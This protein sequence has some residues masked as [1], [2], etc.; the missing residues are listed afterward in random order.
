MALHFEALNLGCHSSDHFITGPSH[1]GLNINPSSHVVFIHCMV[2]CFEVIFSPSPPT[3]DPPP[4]PAPHTLDTPPLP[5]YFITL[6]K[7]KG[8]R[9]DAKIYI[10]TVDFCFIT[11]NHDLKQILFVDNIVIQSQGSQSPLFKTAC[12]RILSIWYLSAQLMMQHTKH[13]VC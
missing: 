4:P 13:V 8:V 11:N 6:I 1:L 7:K 9:N 3:L 12:L 2:T 10:Q 5:H